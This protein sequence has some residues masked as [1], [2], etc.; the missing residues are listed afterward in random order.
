MTINSVDILFSWYDEDKKALTW[1]KEKADAGSKECLSDLIG[2]RTELSTNAEEVQANLALL[3]NLSDEGNA[4]ASLVLGVLYNEGLCKD[5]KAKELEYFVREDFEMSDLYLSK[6][7]EEN[8]P[9]ALFMLGMHAWFRC[10]VFDYKNDEDLPCKAP[11]K[12]DFENGKRWLKNLIA[13]AEDLKVDT[14]VREYAQVHLETAKG[15][16]EALEEKENAEHN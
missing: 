5:S 3:K 10:S 14:V 6:A 13:L 9:V 15:F 7:A 12:K 11:E 16:L 4:R 2:I 1:L 8:D